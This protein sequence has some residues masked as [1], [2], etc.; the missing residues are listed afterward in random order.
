MKYSDFVKVVAHEANLSQSVAKR[1]IDAANLVIKDAV[2]SGDEVVLHGLGKFVKKHRDERT[3][4]N[5]TTKEKITIPA[6]DSVVFKVAK[7]FK[8]HL[9]S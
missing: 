6:T 2:K 3:G 7:E 9:N 1:A 4:I 8:E 5:P